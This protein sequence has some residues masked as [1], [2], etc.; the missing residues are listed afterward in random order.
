MN[1]FYR[2]CFLGHRLLAA[3]VTFLLGICLLLGC[4]SPRKT[5]TESQEKAKDTSIQDRPETPREFRAVWVAT[6]ANID[7]PSEPGLPVAQQKQE[8]VDI[9]NRAASMN[10][11][12][13]I[14]QVRPAADALYDSQYEPWSAFLTGEMGQSPVPY[15]DPLEFAVEEAHKR[16]LELHAW[17]NPYRARH[18]ADTGKVAPTHLSQKHPELV[19]DF[20]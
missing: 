3:S 16:G 9:M 7:W 20:G 6:V 18:P 11:N 2:F 13:V 12:A 4:S 19:L 5:I 10:M 14:F 1:D 17:F 8:L 15:Y